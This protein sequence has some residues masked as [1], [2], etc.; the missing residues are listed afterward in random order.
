MGTG[1]RAPL[2]FLLTLGLC[3]CAVLDYLP[4]D[5]R[6][7]PESEVRGKRM[8]SA[9]R[10]P[11]RAP[12]SAPDATDNPYDDRTPVAPAEQEAGVPGVGEVRGRESAFS[13]RSGSEAQALALRLNPASQSLSSYAALAEPLRASLT[14]L[15]RQKAS[16]PALVQ[17]GGSLTWGQ[18]FETAQ[19]LYTLLPRLDADPGLLAEHF[20]WYELAPSPLMTG[21]YSPEVD[22]SLTRQP[23][24]ETPLYAKPPDL[25]QA[26]EEEQSQGRPKAYRAAQGAI[27]PYYDRQA[28]DQGALAGQGLEIAWVK[29]PL[30]AFWL[31][32]EGAGTLR[33]PDGSLRTAQ[34]AASNGYEFQGLGQLLMATGALPREKLQR[35]SIRAWCESNPERAREIMAQNRSFVFF[36][37]RQG[38]SA[39]AM[40]KP[41]TALVSL[42]TDPSLLPLGSVAALDVPLPGQNGGIPVSLR[43]LVLAQDTG[44][45]IRGHRLD[46][47]LGGGDTAERLESGLRTSAGLHLLVSKNALRAK[48]TR[49]Q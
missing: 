42:A 1:L 5:T 6:G 48:Y 37:L 21:Y 30:D 33:L 41:L 36:E 15:S 13:A 44:S 22:A 49:G 3:G 4:R 10:T 9:G 25:R 23:G 7:R 24:Y 11:A 19:E 40:E 14:Y 45:A 31:Q 28:I 43:G 20:V 2:F 32:T 27:Q 34:F 12:S 16:A 18:L 29:S 47:Y 35:E 46:L 17:P 38:F 26:S 8:A 39:G